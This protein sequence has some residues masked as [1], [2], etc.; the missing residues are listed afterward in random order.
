MVKKLVD[1][2][3]EKQNYRAKFGSDFKKNEFAVEDKVTNPTEIS[4]H[5]IAKRGDNTLIQSVTEHLVGLS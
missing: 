5:A 2:E 4:N 3:K 1:N